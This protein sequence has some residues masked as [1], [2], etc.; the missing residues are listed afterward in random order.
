MMMQ[1]ICKKLTRYLAGSKWQ[2]IQWVIYLSISHAVF[3]SAERHGYS[4]FI[5]EVHEDATHY[6]GIAEELETV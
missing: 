2:W 4:S 5:S 3:G 1:L 6:H